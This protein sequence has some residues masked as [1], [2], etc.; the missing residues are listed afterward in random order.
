MKITEI[1]GNN[2][3]RDF[4]ICHLWEEG[5]LTNLQIAGIFKISER[6]VGRIVYKNRVVLTIDRDFEKTKRIKWLKS[7]IHK[8]GDTRKDPLDIQAE[9]RK[10]I[11]GDT[12]I[13][14][15]GESKVVII[16]PTGY[17][18]PE[19]DARREV[20]RNNTQTIPG[21]LSRD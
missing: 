8:A 6:C 14:Q 12:K 10:E 19:E 17:K 7:Q 15:G 2:K 16:Y 5:L 11:D 3:L 1:K 13:I 21:S 18:K 4:K 20:N 9:L